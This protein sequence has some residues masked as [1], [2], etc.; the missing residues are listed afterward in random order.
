MNMKIV[1]VV[2]EVEFHEALRP[3]FV[4]CSGNPAMNVEIERKK[5]IISCLYVN[6]EIK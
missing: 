6:Y 5:E 3:K 1:I 4:T 2:D